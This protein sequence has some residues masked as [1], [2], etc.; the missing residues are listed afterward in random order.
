L[1]IGFSSVK[2]ISAI[3]KSGVGFFSKKKEPWDT[4]QQKVMSW[5]R[6]VT[7]Q[8]AWAMGRSV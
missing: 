4:S 5:L 2:A 8:W 3:S 7:W 6:A 1:E